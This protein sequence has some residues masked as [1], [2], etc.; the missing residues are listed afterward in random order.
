[1]PTPRT[2]LALAILA[3]APFLGLICPCGAAEPA[4]PSPAVEIVQSR[5]FSPVP[6]SPR[7][8]S[9]SPDE[10]RQIRLDG[11]WEVA[12]T[13]KDTVGESLAEAG[14]LTWT[15]LKVPGSIQ[16]A[17]FEAGKIENPWVADNN[18]R[19]QWI[20]SHDWFL[21]KRFSVPAQWKN[22]RIRLQFD[23]ISQ[24]G[25]V[26][27]DGKYLGT[28]EG[29]Q[30]GPT[31][32][33]TAELASGGDH[34]VVVRI[35][36]G[37]GGTDRD[38]MRP[39][40]LCGWQGWGNKYWALGLWQTVRLVATGAA[41]LETP[42]VRTDS[43]APDAAQLW[44]QVMLNN[45]S[46]SFEGTVKTRIKNA[47]NETVWEGETRQTV[48][49]GASYWELPITLKTPELWWPN[50]LGEQPLYR[51]E[52]CL[53]RD[54]HELD[55]ISTRF[56]VRTLEV[57]RN[58]SFAQAPRRSPLI[59][60][61]DEKALT[62]WAAENGDESYRFLFVVNGQPFY[63]TG[64]AWN[65]S[66]DLLTLTPE[67]D[68]WTVR[69]AK[70]NGIRL[71]RMN[72]GNDVFQTEQIM[73]L[74]DEN[75]I[76]VWQELLLCGN[77]LR[78][79]PVAV[80]REQLTQNVLRIR[81]HP[82]L[83][84]YVGG[85][86]FNAYDPVLAPFLGIAREL[87]DS[88][89]NRPFRMSSPTFN[90]TIQPGGGTYHAYWIP[91]AWSGDP[92]WY[93]NI[94]NEGCNF[95]SE[96]SLYAYA[97]YSSMKRYVPAAE[98]NAGPVGY[99]LEAFRTAHPITATERF[100]ERDYF[101]YP[102]MKA[103]W[104]GDLAKAGLAELAEYS[105]M[106][107]GQTYGYAFEHW[108]SQ[109]P[110]TGG[111]TAWVWNVPQP[112]SSWALIDWFGQPAIGYYST[113]RANEPVHV[114]ARTY[115]FSW[116]P[117]D[118]FHATV[119]AVNDTAKPLD[120]A[121]MSARVL[122]RAMKPV[123]SQSWPVTVPAAGPHSETRDITWAIPVETPDSYFFLEVTLADS[124]GKRL[125]QQAYW[126]R[127]VQ[128]LADPEAR[129]QWQSKPSVDAMC[130]TGPW[131]KPQVEG[132]PTSLEAKILSARSAGPEAEIRLVVRNTGSH[133]AFPVS[134]KIAP[135]VYSNLWDE[136]YFWLPPG[137]SR[138]LTGLVRLDM[139]GLDPIMNPPVAKLEDLQ[140]EVSAWNAPASSLKVP[141][142][143][144]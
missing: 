15:P 109:F 29:M 42:L 96:W 143:G 66:D 68:S 72:A 28:H 81:Q 16:N 61:G 75:G 27:L 113:K 38:V 4:A 121:T 122:D 1:M 108:R 3:L 18:K 11:N 23:G 87:F 132:L 129:K 102:V 21:R 116:G 41:Y 137:E 138:E 34:E 74:C 40:M 62:T 13:G 141:A 17:L 95:A 111:Q 52:F 90:R 49:G 22:R 63:A 37:H 133:P 2:N 50:G 14:E 119:C 6:V 44:A 110:Y 76:L 9:G 30:G 98:L 142:G 92:N 19:L 45:T 125:S 20:S 99:D 118:T 131:L 127:V 10:I 94:W 69:A 117:G 88:Y 107:H 84:I 46:D 123:A 24:T 53:L 33:V 79:I 144:H 112:G 80:W 115:W 35:F 106:A 104:Y 83:A 124:A 114:L 32:D 139:K 56:G 48:P 59:T 103:S 57:R 126:M 60:S 25:A 93:K 67:R 65:M 140:V 39:S 86:E 85:N 43:L 128:S 5:V 136:N 64:A 130:K 31:F 47:K 7:S 100:N 105:Q 8:E 70:A 82:S 73:N 26:W 91:D 51:M 55:A 54:G 36:A 120:K 71:F 101:G 97:N 78:H 77:G 12:D 134:V 89:D 58:P 135:D